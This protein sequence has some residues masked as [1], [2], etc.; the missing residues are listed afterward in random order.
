MMFCVTSAR[1]SCFLRSM[2]ETS[3]AEYVERLQL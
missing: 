2:F 3:D 1:F